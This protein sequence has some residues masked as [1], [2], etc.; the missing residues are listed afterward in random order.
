MYKKREN[1]KNGKFYGCEKLYFNN[2]KEKQ[3]IEKR[4]L[5]KAP[6]QSC[7]VTV[8]V[9]VGISVDVPLAKGSRISSEYVQCP[10]NPPSLLIQPSF[11]LL[12]DL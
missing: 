10:F 9:F 2:G 5:T 12:N 4:I 3:E 11:P 8:S 7:F 6:P 1:N